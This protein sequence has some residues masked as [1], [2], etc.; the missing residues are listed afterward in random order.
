M[1]LYWYIAE[2]NVPSC[3]NNAELFETNST[4]TRNTGPQSEYDAWVASTFVSSGRTSG[5]FTT[6]VTINSETSATTP[7]TP[8]SQ[9]TRRGSASRPTA[10]KIRADRMMTSGG[11]RCVM[12]GIA[13]RHPNPPP[14]R[15]AK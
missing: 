10:A 4:S 13:A 14:T 11:P 6:F 7:P 9:P 3:S 1:S 5:R 15:S 12:S 2:P 8:M